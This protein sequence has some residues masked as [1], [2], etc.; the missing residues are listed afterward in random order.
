MKFAVTYPTVTHFY[1]WIEW[2]KI[3]QL[4]SVEIGNDVEVGANTT[5]DCGAIENTV[6]GHGVKID[7]LVQ[8][9][10]NVVIGDNSAIA[11]C[12]GIAG[13]TVIGESCTLAGGVGVAGHLVI[14]YN[15]HITAMSLVTRSIN[16]PSL[17]TSRYHDAQLRCLLLA[18]DGHPAQQDA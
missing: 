18:E 5:I 1:W 13:S 16:Q 2:Q 15:V 9:A 17:Q 10:H 8:I 6:I 12:V 4:G 14:G 3:H 7:N 11:G